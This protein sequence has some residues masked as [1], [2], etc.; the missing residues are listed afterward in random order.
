MVSPER[1]ALNPYARTEHYVSSPQQPG[2]A[3]KFNQYM[4][5]GY[6][7]FLAF[8]ESNSV[9]NVKRSEFDHLLLRH[10][11]DCG[12]LVFQS[13]RV[14][15]IQFQTDTDASS[16]DDSKPAA[17]GRP[18][19]ATYMTSSGVKGEITF[20]FLIDASGRAGI[21]TTKYACFIF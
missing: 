18:I 3:I 10:A 20:D 2:S 6:V 17:P 8:G 16:D 5:E 7:D 13:C 21:M 12:A 14:L 19:S 11:E 4:Q 9:W 1:Y 15:S